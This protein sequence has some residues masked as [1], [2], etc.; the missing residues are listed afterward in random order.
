MTISTTPRMATVIQPDEF[1][2]HRHWYP[3]ALNATIHPMIN[4]FLN[5][6][7]ERIISR[8]CHMHPTVDKEQLREIL[9][10]KCKYFVWGGADLL[11][12]T[13]AGGKRQ[14]V[15]IENNSC[16]SG[17]KSMPLVDDNQE[18]GS[19]RLMVERTFK[20]YL[21]NLRHKIKGGLAVLYDKNPMEVSGYAEVIADVMQEPVYYVPFYKDDIDP[22]VQFRDGVMYVRIEDGQFVP[23]RAAFRYVTQKPWNRLP[24][25]S[26]TRILNPTIACLAGGR[27]KMVAAKAYDIFNTELESAG[28]KINTPETIWDVSKNEVPLWVRKMGRHAVIKVPYSNAGQGV[29]TIVTEE[30]LDK[31]MEM[32]F[33]YDLFIVQSLIGNYNWSSTTA[34]GKLYHVGT[35]PNQ[36][37]HSFVADIRMMVSSTEKG[38]RPLVTYARRAEKPLVDNIANG[39]DS[40]KM[41]GTNLSIKNADG[42]W[43]SDTNRLVL[44]DRRD[45]NQLGIGLDDLIEAFIQTVLSMVAIDKMAKTLVNKSG[46]FRMKLFRSLNDDQGLINEIKVN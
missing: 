4:F 23:I 16:P 38:I 6:E 35:V 36:K 18:Q 20:P 40:W 31:F 46:K 3:K 11:N 8:Y 27:N 41:L 22:P 9:N 25:H 34:T 10:Y 26:K 28:L 12:V 37:N 33:D 13:S 45:F 32:E 7:Q 21:K 1:E 44:M 5:L 2:A 30:E 43:D 14:M 42:S 19:Y 39:T 17:Q 24:L 15:V 29:Y